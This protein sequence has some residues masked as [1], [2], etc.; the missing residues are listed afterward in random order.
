MSQM[1][2]ESWHLFHHSCSIL[3]HLAVRFPSKQHAACQL[4]FRK[5]KKA[6]V[7]R[8]CQDIDETWTKG[9]VLAVLADVTRVQQA[10]QEVRKISWTRCTLLVNP[11][12]CQ[13]VSTVGQAYLKERRRK[14]WLLHPKRGKTEMFLFC[15]TFGF[16]SQIQTPN[17]HQF[18]RVFVMCSSPCN[19]FPCCQG[20]DREIELLRSSWVSWQDGLQFQTKGYAMLKSTILASNGQG[21]MVGLLSVD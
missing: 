10:V 15:F 13:A 18:Y 20:Q 21:L 14:N 12:V 5:A 7:W 9:E 11:T 16:R 8:F 2:H 6:L 17:V 3:Q 1:I 19:L 4:P